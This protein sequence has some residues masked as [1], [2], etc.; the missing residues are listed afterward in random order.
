[1]LLGLFFLL[2][3]DFGL[4]LRC[5]DDFQN[6]VD[7]DRV[8][9]S[10]LDVVLRKVFV[11]LASLIDP[12]TVLQAHLLQL[13]QHHLDFLSVEAVWE[14]RSVILAECTEHGLYDF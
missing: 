14:L 4:D 13:L 12:S 3:L 1:M 2:S 6:F 11:G 9:A 5:G 7:V 10:S 8:V